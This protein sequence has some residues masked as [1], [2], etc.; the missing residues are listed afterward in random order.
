MRVA[1]HPAAPAV[2]PP[3]RSARLP[4][5]G[6]AAWLPYRDIRDIWAASGS[7]PRLVRGGNGGAHAAA[8][9]ALPPDPS[10]PGG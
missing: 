9:P 2:V 6:G 7:G 1:E 3:G 5:G 10:G 8:A 4:R